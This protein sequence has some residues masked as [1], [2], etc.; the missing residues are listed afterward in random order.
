MEV[1]HQQDII[2][3]NIPARLDRLPWSAWHTRIVIAL[4]ITWLLDGL[5]TT[6]G[7]ALVGIL[8]DPRTLHLS[9][10]QI[11]LSA[12]VYLAGAVIGALGF[13]YATDRLGRKRLFFITLGLYLLATAATAFSWNFWSF[14][15]FRGLT[16]A[17][18]GGEYA[19]INSAVDELI[20]ARVRGHVD[21]MINA[22]F[23]LGAILGSLGA[24]LVL[25]LHHLPPT[26]SWRFVFGIGAVLG[27]GVLILRRYV[28]ES[29]RWLL[30]H[31]R[32]EEADQVV[33]E[34][35]GQ[36]ARRQTLAPA[37]G[38]IKLQVQ[39]HTPWRDIWNAMAT[40]IGSA[41]S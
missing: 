18:I 5:E 24:V 9:D 11:G 40:S 29:P 41:R 1:A 30:I 36:I 26:L 37:E 38:T 34:I 16:G 25:H 19:A 15:L 17:G 10:S 8:K 39:D 20:P 6:L 22:T 7:G 33:A 28:P 32:K 21:L 27:L 31:G 14:S 4:G 12:T 35:E 2:E 23:W 3:S 13:G